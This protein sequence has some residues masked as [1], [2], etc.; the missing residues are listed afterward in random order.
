MVGLPAYPVNN[1]FLELVF[2]NVAFAHAAPA[3]GDARAVHRLRVAR[4]QWMPARQRAALVE[5]AV[6][7]CPRQP[8][9]RADLVGCQA[10]AVGNFANAVGVVA[11]A[12]RLPVQQTTGRVCVPYNN[13]RSRRTTTPIPRTSCDPAI[14]VPRT[15]ARG[16]RS[17]PVR[18]PRFEPGVS[19]RRSGRPSIA[20]D[21]APMPGIV[22]GIRRHSD[23]RR[24]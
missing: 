19:V 6:G 3:H 15:G 1:V 8:A 2:V 21:R 7:A 22:H 23:S 14:C 4:D 16:Y 18:R 24:R 10:Y 9:Q 12:A 13:D 20:T 5:P 11:A 17:R